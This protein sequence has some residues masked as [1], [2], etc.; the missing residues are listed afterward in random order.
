MKLVLV[1]RCIKKKLINK[2]C[3]MLIVLDNHMVRRKMGLKSLGLE[4]I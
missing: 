1:I 4:M 3:G 2:K